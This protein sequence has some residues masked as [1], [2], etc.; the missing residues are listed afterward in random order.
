MHNFS[1]DAFC[2]G[3]VIDKKRGNV[4]KVDRHKYVRQAYHGMQELSRHERKQ[5]YTKQV[6]RYEQ[7]LALLS[8]L[9]STLLINMIMVL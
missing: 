5:I 9:R 6:I 8:F 4:L 2:R 3:L 1:S 7:M